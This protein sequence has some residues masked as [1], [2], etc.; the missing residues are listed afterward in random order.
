MIHLISLLLLTDTASIVCSSDIGLHY[1]NETFHHGVAI[2]PHFSIDSGLIYDFRIHA[3]TVNIGP[4][5][6]IGEN[7]FIQTYQC[8]GQLIS[9][10]DQILQLC[11]D[12]LSI[13]ESLDSLTC[14]EANKPAMSAD[15][16][17]IIM[18]MDSVT[19]YRDSLEMSLSGQQ[20]AIFGFHEYVVVN[21]IA[22]VKDY[23][24]RYVNLLNSE[25]CESAEIRLDGRLRFVL[26][27]LGRVIYGHEQMKKLGT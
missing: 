14:Q 7:V 2:V 23:A 8:P 26:D 5:C 15:A 6:E 16:L 20:L 24:Q 10:N 18:K 12:A 13:A 22:E 19:I 17:L 21:N 27:G 11:Y 3:Q 9:Y 25:P 1:N 4:E